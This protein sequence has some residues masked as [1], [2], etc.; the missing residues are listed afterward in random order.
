MTSQGTVAK[1][2]SEG[3]DT[4]R[5]E[6]R[7]QSRAL[8]DYHRSIYS[9]RNGEE[10]PGV[11][12]FSLLCDPSANGLRSVRARVVGSKVRPAIPWTREDAAIHA[13]RSMRRR[14]LLISRLEVMVRYGSLAEPVG[15]KIDG[16]RDYIS[17][18][19]FW[20][21]G[22]GITPLHSTHRT[23]PALCSSS[24][25]RSEIRR[26]CVQAQGGVSGTDRVVLLDPSRFTVHLREVSRLFKHVYGIVVLLC[27][28]CKRQDM[29]TRRIP[30]S[31]LS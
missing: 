30:S 9:L 2:L 16:R 18:V 31:P 13:V 17:V 20:R 23:L 12:G 7:T 22:S 15:G 6:G 4:R 26:L 11:N 1:Y 8:V 14:G 5:T 21:S 28:Q 24:V 3:R 27:P 10:V 19:P 29:G 25:T